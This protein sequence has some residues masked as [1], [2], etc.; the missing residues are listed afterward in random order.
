MLRRHPPAAAVDGRAVGE[1][2]GPDAP[3]DAVAGLEH[4][5]GLAGLHQAASGRE[6]RVAG[7][8]HTD[9][10]VDL[11]RHR[12]QNLGEEPVSHPIGDGLDVHPGELFVHLEVVLAHV[13]GRRSVRR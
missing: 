4:H 13:R 1:V 6:P 9:V 11:P 2:F 3:A 8:H 10:A 7:T 5:D 12:R